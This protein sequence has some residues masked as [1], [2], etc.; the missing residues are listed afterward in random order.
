MGKLMIKEHRL[1]EFVWVVAVLA[2]AQLCGC[3][4]THKPPASSE[5]YVFYPPG[6]DPPR[7]QF[8]V[9]FNDAETWLKKRSSFADFIVGEK[10]ETRGVL[11]SPFGIAARDGKLYICDL[12]KDLI[13]IIDLGQKSYSVL[14]TPDQIQNPTSITIDTDGTKYVCDTKR[15]MVLV[16]DADDNFVGE[17]GDPQR[18]APL[19]LAIW[20]DELF[21]SD[22]DRE[23]GGEIEVW[24]KEGKLLRTISSRGKGPDQLSWPMFL[25]IGPDGHV[26]VV[27]RDAAMVKEFDLKGNF[28]KT[29]GERGDIAGYF[30][31]P[32]G[33][34]I[35]PKGRLYVADSVWSNVQIF[36]SDGQILLVVGGPGTA[37]EGMGV[38]AGL[39][40][41][42]TSLDVFG[43][44]LSKDFEAE[45]LLFVVTQFGPYKMGKIGVYAFGHKK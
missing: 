35:D 28:I 24:S 18:C 5:K 3:I 10:K 26:F 1:S 11:K 7:L 8:L 29:I 13:H 33:I 14:G 19:D 2:V 38:L 25:E 16:Y 9:S 45:Y 20:G 36:S 12:G 6:P 37:P 15:R 4:S 32:K 41:D 44:F 43:R 17:L 22:I 30:Q 27:D 21:V 23:H 39:A 42:K 34:A 31:T 40:I